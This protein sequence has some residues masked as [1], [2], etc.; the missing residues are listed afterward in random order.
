MTVLRLHGLI[1]EPQ[2]MPFREINQRVTLLGVFDVTL[3][4][5]SYC[6]VHIY[7]G[8]SERF[9]PDFGLMHLTS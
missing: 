2:P 4:F 9:G 1:V 5:A 8:L 3:R 6:L 7:C